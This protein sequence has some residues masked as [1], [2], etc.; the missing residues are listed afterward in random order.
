MSKP[1]TSCNASDLAIDGP[2][3]SDLC[4]GA[5]KGYDGGKPGIDF[6]GRLNGKWFY[7]KRILW[8][9]DVLEIYGWLLA[10]GTV[11]EWWEWFGLRRVALEMGSDRGR[12]SGD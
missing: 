9:G 3:M 12:G 6:L 2:P 7:R 4:A 8:L 10:Q 1:S 5:I 11:G